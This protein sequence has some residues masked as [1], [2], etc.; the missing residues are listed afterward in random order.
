MLFISN[1][2]DVSMVHRDVSMVHVSHILGNVVA[3]CSE[4]GS[5]KINARRRQPMAV[6][7]PNASSINHMAP[8]LRTLSLH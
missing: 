6:V 5:L 7:V 4:L 2:R 8:A 3:V 1:H